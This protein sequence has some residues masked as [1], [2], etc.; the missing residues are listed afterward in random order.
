VRISELV[1]N[2]MAELPGPVNR[3]ERVERPA[4]PS[5]IRPPSEQLPPTPKADPETGEVIEESECGQDPP[6]NTLNMLA[7]CIKPDGHSG[8]HTSPE[9]SWPQ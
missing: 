7:H 4:L 5:G 8:A 6:A 3:R 2:V 9:G 1:E